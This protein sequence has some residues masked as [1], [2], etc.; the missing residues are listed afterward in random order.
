M[1]QNAAFQALVN[2][3]SLSRSAAKGLPEQMNVVPR[4]SG[5]GFSV[6]GKKFVAPM[7]Q[8]TEL[9]ELPSSTRLPG[10]QPWVIGLSNVRGRL[11]PLF[12]LAHFFE[13]KMTGHKK[14]H[15]VLVLETDTLYSGLVVDRAFG[16]Q[17]FNV[18][19]FSTDT[20]EL[21]SQL[22]PFVD[23]TYQDDS[24]ERWNVFSVANLAADARF[25]NA[26]L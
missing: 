3:S 22:T 16:M 17:H 26:A 1:S 2:L 21:D 14:N 23:G 25:I 6:M 18:D 11:L 15:R 7:G 19:S 12:D 24:G 10:V 4:W 8:V 20:A 9:M 13:G 5:V